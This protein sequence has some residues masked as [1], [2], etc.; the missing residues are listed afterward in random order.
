MLYG[1]RTTRRSDARRNRAAI[2]AAAT[3]LLEGPD[4]AALMATTARR[5]GVALATLYRHFPDR[6]A[7]TA[8]VIDTLL[9]DLATQAA[10]AAD[11]PWTFRT[12]LRTALRRQIRMRPLVTHAQRLSEALR[13]R[14]EQRITAILGLP[15]RRAQELGLARPDL[16][17]ADLLL[18]LTMLRGVDPGPRA[19][20]AV[21]LLLDGVFRP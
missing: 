18:L 20:L 10:A 16:A 6:H 8:A 21:D 9:T 5:A 12:L 2:V 17:P 13:H 7:L 14:Y 19:D 3:T 11:N 15:L 1:A 4:D